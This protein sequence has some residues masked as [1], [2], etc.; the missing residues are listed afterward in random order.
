MTRAVIAANELGIDLKNVV[1]VTGIA[2]GK[3]RGSSQI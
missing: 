1:I 3:I 2:G